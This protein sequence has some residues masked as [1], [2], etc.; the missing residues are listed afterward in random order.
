[1]AGIL[2]S[3]GVFA[4]PVSAGDY[5]DGGSRYDRYSGG[6]RASS[7]CCY[8]KVV[9]YVRKV[10]YRRVHSGRSHHGYEGQRYGYSGRYQS[11]PGYRYSSG[12]YPSRSY[13]NDS[14]PRYSRYAEYRGDDCRRQR[15]SD[16][17]GG[18]LWSERG[19]CY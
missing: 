17:R 4:T 10:E 7:D 6:H 12:S 11:E 18:W 9:R 2:F 3:V 5:Y 16:G 13:V 15:L 8:Q 1:M 19:R 14:Y